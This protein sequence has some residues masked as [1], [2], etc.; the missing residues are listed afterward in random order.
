MAL[1]NVSSRGRWV[2]LV[3]VAAAL[4]AWAACGGGGDGAT[5]T[6]ARVVDAAVDA[7]IDG[8]SCGA[9]TCGG[10]QAD[11]C[12]D[13][14]HCGDCTTTCAAGYACQAGDCACPPPFVPATPVFIQQQLDTTTLPGATLGIGGMLD[15]TIDG[16]IIGYPTATVQVNHAYDLAGRPPGTPPLAAVGYDVDLQTLTPSAAFYATAGTLTFTR[17]C[18]GGFEGT[19]TAA[20]FVAVAG[21]MNPTLVVNGCAFDVPSITFAYGTACPPPG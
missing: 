8:P 13:E 15:S 18:A 19:L 2:A 11:T 5:P 14:Q 21:L 7:A 17:I 9:A 4:T 16:M 3:L 10:A 12:L 1:D 20:H 6:D